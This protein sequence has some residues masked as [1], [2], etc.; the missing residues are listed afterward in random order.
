MKKITIYI[1]ALILTVST[2]CNKFLDTVPSDFAVPEQF[3]NTESQLNEALAGVYNSLTTTATY[4]LYISSY[5]VGST[6]AEYY[7]NTGTHPARYNIV[8]SESRINSTWNDLY[9]GI[10]LANHLLANI[11]KPSMDARKRAAI[12]GEAL[13]L[14]AFMY[15]HLVTLW[16]DVPM[17]LEP[18]TDSRKTNHPKVAAK[19]IYNKIIADMTE[20]NMLVYP[21]T[22]YNSPSRVSKSA[23]QGI[24]ARVCLSMAGEP[25]KDV[26]KYADA[27]NWADSVIQGNIHKLNTDYIQ[28]FKNQITD[29]YDNQF[30]ESIWEIDF[31]GNN[32]DVYRIGGRWSTYGSV[33]NTNPALGIGYS[34]GYLGATPYLYKAYEAGDLRRDWAIAPYNYQGNNTAVKVYKPVTNYDRMMGKWRRDY[35]TIIPKN[36]EYNATNFP[37]LRYADIL[38][39][40][41]EAESM[42]GGA[43][44][45]PTPKAYDAL[46]QVRRRAFGLPINTPSSSVSVV[47]ALTLATTGNTGYDKE[48]N[49][50]P[51]TFAGGGGTGALGVASVSATSGKVTGVH[52]THPGS[53]Y[54]SA[55]TVI[56]GTQWQANTSYTVGQQVFNGTRLYTVQSSGTSSAVGPTHTTGTS[57]P[58]Q[59]GIGFTYAGLRATATADIATSVI[60]ISGL[61]PLAFQDLIRE[62]RARELAFEGLRKQDLIRWG[63]FIERLKAMI[64]DMVA[65]GW[66]AALNPYILPYTV[67]EEKHK[68][69]P[70]P[71]LEV[72]LNRAMEQHDLWK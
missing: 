18:T 47:S 64:P 39:M 23:V 28:I 33:R 16:G 51:I 19:D 56:I 52:I 6:D 44:Q 46:N 58:A 40:Y 60:D 55:P 24:L 26:S 68:V 21:Y 59:T 27:K 42:I 17:M 31:Y 10:N 34:Y 30:K 36:N 70:I 5:Y 29:K 67:V 62:E 9:S 50:I 61:S 2:S 41:A 13:F 57:N 66:P 25:V 14:R 49:E 12:K 11:N 43:P 1:F 65:P 71:L 7:R 15:Y 69:F 54:T 37:V 8:T 35:E 22:K 45:A 48:V 38:L 53:G 20:A 4:G 32:S 72:N 3:Y 63:I